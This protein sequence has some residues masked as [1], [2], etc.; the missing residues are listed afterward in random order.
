MTSEFV[1]NLDNMG[2]I[3]NQLLSSSSEHHLKS[4]GTYSV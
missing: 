4:S 3:D 2:M 1:R